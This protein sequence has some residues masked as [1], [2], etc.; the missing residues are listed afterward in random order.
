ML[1]HTLP[2]WALLLVGMLLL[3]GCGYTFPHVYEGPHHSIYMPTWQNRTNK[4][5]LDM[6]IYQSLSRWFQKSASVDLTKDKGG[7]DL[8]LTG[9]ILSIDLPSVSWSTISEVTG[10]KVNLVIRYALKDQR[11]GK[12]LWEVPAKLYSADYTVSTVSAAADEAALTKIIDDL[13]EDIY[14]GALRRIRKQQQQ[15]QPQPT[16]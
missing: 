3:S 1:K 4:L 15:Q 6:K 8:I 12:V 13:S 10:T 5:G 14:L 7:A 16:P 11:T 2:G 9:E